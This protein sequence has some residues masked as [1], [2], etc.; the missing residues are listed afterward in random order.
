VH[1]DDICH[2][3]KA[4]TLASDTLIEPHTALQDALTL[5]RF[6]ARTII[7]NTQSYARPTPTGLTPRR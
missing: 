1:G 5:C 3:R 2:H 7:L 4:N 6:D